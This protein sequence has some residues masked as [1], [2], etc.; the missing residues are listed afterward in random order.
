MGVEI[1]GAR[2]ENVNAFDANLLCEPMENV[3]IPAFMYMCRY[4]MCV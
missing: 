4:F 1:V 2:C 3:S